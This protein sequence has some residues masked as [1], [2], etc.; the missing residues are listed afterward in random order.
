MGKCGRIP[1]VLELPYQFRVGE[2]LT[3]IGTSQR[4][5]LSQKNRFVYSVELKEILGEC[6]LDH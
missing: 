5:E 6:R 2:Y 4:K 1:R 3:G